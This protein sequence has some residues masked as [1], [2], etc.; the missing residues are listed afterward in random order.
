MRLVVSVLMLSMMASCATSGRVQIKR[1]PQHREERD[2]SF[3]ELQRKTDEL[4]ERVE[5][6]ESIIARNRRAPDALE[7]APD[8]GTPPTPAPAP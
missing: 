6:L 1:W 8:P 3:A 2:A 4:Q 7:P 5:A